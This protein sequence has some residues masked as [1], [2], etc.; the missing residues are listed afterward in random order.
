MAL[1]CDLLHPLLLIVSC[2]ISTSAAQGEMN[3]LPPAE[4]GTDQISV[5]EVVGTLSLWLVFFWVIF[6]DDR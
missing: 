2:W 5:L 1:D 3:V 6:L 4:S